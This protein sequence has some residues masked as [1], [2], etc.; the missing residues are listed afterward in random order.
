MIHFMRS[1]EILR[2]YKDKILDGHSVEV[3]ISH[4]E[5]SI[6]FRIQFK[7]KI[8]FFAAKA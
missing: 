8:A 3:C 5:S 7:T 2:I 1:Q 6:E 4:R